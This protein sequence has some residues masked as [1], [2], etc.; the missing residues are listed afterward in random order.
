MLR[1][2]HDRTAPLHRRR[3]RGRQPL[4][5]QASG[6]AGVTYLV[7]FGGTIAAGVVP[8]LAFVAYK[9]RKSRQKEKEAR[10]RRRKKIEL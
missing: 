7:V 1:V 4:E 3:R 6:E 10:K 5:A 2:R 8:V 9:V